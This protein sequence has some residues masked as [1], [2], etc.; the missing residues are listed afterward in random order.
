MGS[1][2]LVFRRWALILQGL[3]AAYFF[4]SVISLDEL[5]MACPTFDRGFNEQSVL[6]WRR[7]E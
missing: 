1:S 2:S 5:T 3:I 6:R 7:Q 4:A